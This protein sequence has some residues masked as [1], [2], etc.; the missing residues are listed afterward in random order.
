MRPRVIA[1]SLLVLLAALLGGCAEISVR[2]SN[3]LDLVRDWEANLLKPEQLSPRTVQT[4]RRLDLER[5]YLKKPEEAF[6]H[7]EA[8]ADST[9]E[10]DAIFALAEMAYIFGVRHE[11][12]NCGR[13]AMWFYHSAGYAYHYVFPGATP[14]T[15]DYETVYDPRFRL[16]CDL[17]NAGL[18]KCIR[19]AQKAGRLDPGQRLRLPTPDGL[20]FELSVVQHGFCWRPEEFGPLLFCSDYQ[21]VGLENQYRGYGLGVP[22]MGTR[23][24]PAPPLGSERSLGPL[25]Y[26]GNVCFPVTAFFRFEGTLADLRAHRS[27][28]LEL[29]NPLA[30]EMVEVGGRRIPLESDLTTPLAYLLSDTDLGDLELLGF[31]RGDKLDGKQGLYSL[32]PYQP[33]KIP[34]VM[35]HGL[36]SSPVTWA[37]MF[38]DLRADP[39]LREHFQFWFYRYPTGQPYMVTAAD[40]RETMAQ[41]REQLDPQHRDPALDRMVF[42]GH[43]MGGLVSELMTQDSGDDIWRLISSQ[44]FE[45]LK[46][47]PT[48]RSELERVLFFQRQPYVRRVVFLGTPHHGSQ[49]SPSFPARVLVYFAKLPTRLLDAVQDAMQEN[50][51]FWT[52]G[53]KNT[54]T[55]IDLLAPNSPALE[56]LASRPK[57]D[58]VAYHSIIGSAPGG[59]PLRQLAKAFGEKEPS[60]GVV[61]IR[62]AHRDGVDSEL[63]VEA[64]HTHVHQHPLAVLE[65]RRILLEHWKEQQAEVSARK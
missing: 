24:E 15:C 42:V 40:L 32:E 29:Y 62:S 59:N 61:P 33:G 47:K 5:I 56:L 10:P 55:S 35:V 37:P 60:D 30:V 64:D 20:G 26:P 44:P 54:P 19:A 18:T 63:I 14:M 27:G 2:K 43:S 39:E 11:K 34:V 28:T 65:V 51:Q 52:L 17:Y 4:L 16:A 48:S 1:R 38:N 21:V 13:A 41:V 49:L 50:P 9:A 23:T 6:T 31:L 57:P 58:G 7:L 12:C 53:S 25:R 22:L 46:L 45:S 36:L 3:A 8:I